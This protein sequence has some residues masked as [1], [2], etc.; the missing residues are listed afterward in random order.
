MQGKNKNEVLLVGDELDVQSRLRAELLANAYEVTSVAHGEEGLADAMGSR[1]DVVVSEIE[2]RGLSGLDLL[3]R[4][5][6]VHPH[7]PV[8][9]LAGDANAE[10]SIDAFRY[11]AHDFLWKPFDLAELIALIAKAVS[12]PCPAITIP[13][14][15]FAGNQLIG[16]SPAMRELHKR[17]GIA[18][19]SSET[20]LITGASGTG[21]ELIA[22]A[23][24]THSN[25]PGDFVACNC[26]AV[27]ESL[28]ESH[29]FGHEKGAFTGADERRIGYFELA[30]KG[31]LFLDEIG[32]LSLAGQAKLLRVLQESRVRRLG[33][34]YEIKIDLRVI[35][36]THH[37]LKKLVDAH[38]FREDLFYRL[39][40]LTIPTPQ[41][42]EHQEIIPDLV[43]YFL[44]E[45]QN[46]EKHWGV[47]SIQPEAVGFLKEHHW[48][49]NIRQLRSAVRCAAANARGRPITLTHVQEACDGEQEHSTGASALPNDKILDELFE[50]ARAGEIDHVRDRVLDQ[51]DRPLFTRAMKDAQ[52]NQALAARLLGVSRTTMADKVKKFGLR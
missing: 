46:R 15:K 39:K 17:I 24:H 11:G 21:K 38:K 13:V 20:V 26:T 22:N 48:P 51:I 4:L 27:P 23:I 8:I 44:L 29:F 18:A 12:K 47:I 16:S 36:A 34:S 25:R 52:G 30:D 3:K 5:R 42:C 40:G 31:T 41:L 1:C 49:G 33:C 50:K 9:L 14:A 10:T 35:S 19:D 45:I 32:D 6:P 37:S 2:P 7:L 28:F 43:R